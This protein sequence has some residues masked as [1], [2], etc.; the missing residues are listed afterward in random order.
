MHL[1]LVVKRNVQNSPLRSAVM[2][3]LHDMSCMTCYMKFDFSKS[4]F[5]QKK[6]LH[7][8]TEEMLSLSYVLSYLIIALSLHPGKSDSDCISML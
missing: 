7:R 3:E 4:D 6:L 5:A 2:N 8:L 1:C